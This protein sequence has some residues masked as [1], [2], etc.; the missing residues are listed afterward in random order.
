MSDAGGRAVAE[1]Q[2]LFALD[3]YDPRRD[4]TSAAADHSRS[5]ID[6]IL[7]SA[8]WL[9]EVPYKGDGQVEWC[10]MFAAACWHGAGIDPRWLATYFA[11]TYRLDIWARYQSF[12]VKHPN[13]KPAAGPYR[14]IAN[15]DAHSTSLPWDPEPG[16]IVM[17]GDG[18]PE[19]GDHITVAVSYDAATK[20]VATISG[21]GVGMGPD[22]KRRQG[23]V[24]STV[25][26]GGGGY[27][28]R[29]VIRPAESDV[30]QGG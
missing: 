18:A 12:D 8:G 14:T 24:K 7:T 10:G 22:G 27:C 6:A 19:Y 2:R 28:I 15:A 20:T 29:R 11:S 23:I 30:A 3:V 17:I 4:D 26:L 9:W 16:D 1:A 21:N 13:P 25:H 5:V